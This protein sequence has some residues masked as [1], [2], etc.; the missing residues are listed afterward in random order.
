MYYSCSEGIL[1]TISPLSF[2][3][4]K[5][6]FLSCNCT[7]YILLCLKET[8]LRKVEPTDV[9]VDKC[10]SSVWLHL[11]YII[12]CKPT[13][14]FRWASSNKNTVDHPVSA[15]SDRSYPLPL[16]YREHFRPDPLFSVE[17]AIHYLR[18]G[19]ITHNVS[20]RYDRRL[21]Q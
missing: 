18:G 5:T 2:V 15:R 11:F 1:I 13:P 9:L 10:N 19:S 12:Y 17:I 20:W 7:L 21:R 4:N 8:Q 14:K 6:W 3:G 16:H